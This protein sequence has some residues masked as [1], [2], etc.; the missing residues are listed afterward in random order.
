MTSPG[1]R[2]DC[3][4]D[5]PPVARWC[6]G[7]AK[8]WSGNSPGPDTNVTTSLVNFSFV[9]PLLRGGGRALRLN[10][11]TIVERA[12]LANL[13]AFQRYRQGFYT[14]VTVGNGIA[15]NVQVR[16]AAAV[17]SAAPV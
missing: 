15:G 16:N 7:F 1:R 12:L 5:F 10:S 9:Q 13:R 6:V 14:N 3:R 8:S 2:T 4:S 11:L 17:S